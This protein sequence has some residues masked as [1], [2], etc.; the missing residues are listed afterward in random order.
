MTKTFAATHSDI[1]IHW[2]MRISDPIMLSKVH[3]AVFPLDF[4]WTWLFLHPQNHEKETRLQLF[5]M[6]IGDLW[7]IK[8]IEWLWLLVMKQSWTE[9]QMSGELATVESVQYSN[10][11][12]LTV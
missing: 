10:L 3:F 12:T 8:L 9:L 11:V 1:D 2:L 7:L 5:F 4:K 6:N